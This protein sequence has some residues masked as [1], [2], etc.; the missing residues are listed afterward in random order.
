MS[1]RRVIAVVLNWCNEPD[2]AACVD[3]LSIQDYPA[4]DIL[5]VD[6]ASPDES[7]ARLRAR[8]PDMMHER[9]ATN[10]G[11]TGGNNRG[12]ARALRESADFVLVINNDATLEPGAVRE[13]VYAATSADPVGAVGP[14][15]L[16]ADASDVL[17]F[18]GGTFDRRRAIGLHPGQGER[19]T[20]PEEHQA[21]EVSF[22]TGCC[23]LIPAD[24]LREVGSFRED[25]FAYVEDV[26]F[27]LRLSKSGYRLLYAPA[28]RVR[29]RVPPAGTPPSPM[30][31]RLRDRNRRRLARLHYTAADRFR[32]RAWFYPTRV[33]R[34]FGYLLRGDRERARAIVRG[35]WEV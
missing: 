17:W 11:Y 2:T 20:D 32:F 7:G 22:L 4:L 9:T 16:R 28:A 23:L 6:N 25:F 10:L 31:I 24:V 18:A 29:H 13:L 14:K 34:A 35:A 1:A 27:C 3:S 21:R 26:E 5:V 33:A 12:I 15:I 19:D 8:Y 30:Q